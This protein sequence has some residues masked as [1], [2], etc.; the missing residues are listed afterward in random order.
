[1]QILKPSE[2]Q[3]MAQDQVF[4][5]SALSF[6]IANVVFTAIEIGLYLMYKSGKLPLIVF[7]FTC[8]FFLLFL[9][10]SFNCFKKALARTN[11][12]FVISYDRVYIKFRSYLNAN[13][14]END[15][16]II[17]LSFSEIEAAQ[18]IKMRTCSYSLGNEK[19]TQFQKYLDLKVRVEN[20]QQLRERL[21]YEVAAKITKQ[22]RFVKS[23]TKSG[24]YPVSVPADN[25][26]RILW[27]NITPNIKKAVALLERQRVAIK[28][29]QKEFRDYTKTAVQ[30]SG[31][32]DDKILELA[33]Q[34]KTIAAAKLAQ[35]IYDY[36]L[37]QANKFVDGLL[38]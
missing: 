2:V 3:L 12:L 14:P 1:M 7:I 30:E 28:P 33:Q 37:T 22:T 32:P 25:V 16:Q 31:N 11:W 27:S 35:R 20:L 36:D 15:P 23:S 34:G 19:Q 26:I 24:H 8:L 17:S 10:F 13:L 29:V 9:M 38:K 5:E 18:I 21:K 6:F 4:K